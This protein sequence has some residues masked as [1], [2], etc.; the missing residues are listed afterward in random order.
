M[1]I[2]SFHTDVRDLQKE[3]YERLL[4]LRN[5]KSSRIISYEQSVPRSKH[6]H[7]Y[8]DKLVKA[9]REIMAVCPEVVHIFNNGLSN[10]RLKS[11]NSVALIFHSSRTNRQVILFSPE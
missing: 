9:V 7:Y 8:K 10:Y 3:N 11:H 2:R 4:S 1:N 6:N 5:I